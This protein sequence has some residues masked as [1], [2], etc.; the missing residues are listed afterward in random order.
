MVYFFAAIIMRPAKRKCT[1][2]TDNQ[3]DQTPVAASNLRLGDVQLDVVATGSKWRHKFIFTMLW[4]WFYRRQRRKEEQQKK[5]LE[6][7][8]KNHMSKVRKIMDWDDSTL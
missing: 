8:F 1:S 6:T 3:I 7:D 2:F 4:I 5:L